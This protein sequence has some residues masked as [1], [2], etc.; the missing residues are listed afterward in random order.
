MVGCSIVGHK[1]FLS[2]SI[3]KKVKELLVFH[4]KDFCKAKHETQTV[5]KFSDVLFALKSDGTP[6]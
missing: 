3:L 5:F 6:M 2:S 1:R 4:R